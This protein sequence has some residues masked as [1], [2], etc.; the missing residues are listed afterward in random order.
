[1]SEYLR[2]LLGVLLFAAIPAAATYLIILS[3]ER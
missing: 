2:V 3:L 1:M